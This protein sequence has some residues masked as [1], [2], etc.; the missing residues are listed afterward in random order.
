M[1]N[2]SDIGDMIHRCGSNDG[3]HSDYRRICPNNADKAHV[4]ILSEAKNLV[5]NDIRYFAS[6]NMTRNE[7][8]RKIPP[9]HKYLSLVRFLMFAYI[10]SFYF[11]PLSAQ[12]IHFSQYFNAPLSLNPART[13]MFDGTY[14]VGID[15]RNQWSGVVQGRSSFSTPSFYGDVPIRLKSKSIIGV[16]LNIV[17]DK[18]SGGRLSSFSGQIST[19]YH[20]AMGSTKNHFFSL[21]MQVGV[22]HKRLDLANIRLGDQIDLQNEAILNSSADFYNLKGSDGGFDLNIGFGWSSKFSE[23]ASMHLGYAAFHVNKPSIS[24]YIDEQKLPV[25]HLFNFEADFGLASHFRL[26]PFILYMS[27]AGAQQTFLGMSLGFPFSDESGL[28]LGAYYR[29]NDAV[30][31]YMGL[32]IKRFRIGVSY[33]VTTSSLNQTSGGIEISLT[34]S[35]RY[36]SVPSVT[37]SMYS[38]RF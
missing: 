36:I 22:L 34:Y 24:F 7:T 30:V 37:P 28:R 20:Q 16:G 1:N 15:Y 33:D 29:T 4:V 13:G 18:S 3:S 25:R 14:R 26:H 11:L 32:D 17:N 12:D 2:S 5:F 23:R 21:G 27:Q 6:L 31:P 10:L 35:G 38:P 19:A 8:I 9:V